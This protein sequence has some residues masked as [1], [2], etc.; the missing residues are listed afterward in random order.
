[1]SDNN[2]GKFLITFCLDRTGSMSACQDQT[3][4]GFNEFLHQQ[5]TDPNGDAWMSLTLFDR[6]ANDNDIEERFVAVPIAEIPDLGTSANPYEPRG[7]T[8]LYD[9]IGVTIRSCERIEKEYERVLCVIQTDGQEN[10]SRDWTQQ[11]IFDLITEK[12]REGWAFVF[13]GADQDAYAAS[14]AIGVAAGS[15]MAYA[16]GQSVA[17]FEAVSS[18]TSL[19][20]SRRGATADRFFDTDTA[21]TPDTKSRRRGT[22]TP[23]S[24]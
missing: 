1:M 6:P 17:A 15:T 18:G 3:V 21:P 13:M 14:A 7:N 20:R 5:Q 12:R 10:S 16:S 11:T 4:S 24:S 9:A 22:K 2:G 8:P 23:R 19:Y